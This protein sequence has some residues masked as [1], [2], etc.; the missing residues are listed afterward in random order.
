MFMFRGMEI[1]IQYYRKSSKYWLREYVLDLL[2]RIVLFPLV[3]LYKL[4]YW[5]W[6]LDKYWNLTH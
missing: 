1:V 3:L 6:D 5:V 4:W 2:K